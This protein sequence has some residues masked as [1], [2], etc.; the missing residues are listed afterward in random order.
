M[1]KKALAVIAGVTVIATVVVAELGGSSSAGPS[2]QRLLLAP[3]V[4][5]SKG[6]IK[7]PHN[8]DTAFHAAYMGG[9][10]GGTGASSATVEV[11][12]YN[13]AGS[14]IKAPG[15]DQVI[16]GPCTMSLGPSDRKQ[17][18]RLETEILDVGGWGTRKSVLGYAVFSVSGED[19][20][21]VAIQGFVVNSHT[22][23]LDQ[24]V[25]A[26]TP[27]EITLPAPAAP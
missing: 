18:L 13:A 5:E 17:S 12:L 21:H 14:L 22:N 4:F 23:P 8:Q 15:G 27:E 25:T 7:D 24:S 20:D 9:Q 16:C 19:P 26:Y 6:T 2:T 1:T 11:R 10:G 3:H